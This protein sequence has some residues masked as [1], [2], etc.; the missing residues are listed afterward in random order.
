MISFAAHFACLDAQWLNTLAPEERAK[1]LRDRKLARIKDKDSRM[2][3]RLA[4]H[5]SAIW[6][7][8]WFLFFGWSLAMVALPTVTLGVIH[9]WKLVLWAVIG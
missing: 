1:V 6:A 8:R 9:L 3:R 7:R 2:T 4:R 5:R